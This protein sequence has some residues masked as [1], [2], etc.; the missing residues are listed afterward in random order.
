[1]RLLTN[2]IPKSG[3]H[4]LVKACELLGQPTDVSHITFSQGRPENVTHHLFIKRDPRNILISWMRFKSIPVTQGMFISTL[5][6][7]EQDSEKPFIDLV[8]EYLPWLT[9][10]DV[11]VVKFEDLISDGG[12]TI[13]AIAQHLSVP[14]LSDAYDNLPGLTRT[15]TGKYSDYTGIWTPEVQ[16]EWR[17]AGGED[18]LKEMGYAS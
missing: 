17:A 7:Y 10:P 2:G 9:A 4:A 11:F 3:G 18:I 8:R 1:M 12:L 5:K 14:Y 13:Q 15:W 6:R 16:A